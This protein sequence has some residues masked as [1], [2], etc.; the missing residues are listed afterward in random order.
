MA[1]RRENGAGTEPVLKNR[2]WECHAQNGFKPDGSK[3]IIYG[4]G[5]TKTEARNNLKL[6]LYKINAGITKVTEFDHL[7]LSTAILNYLEDYKK[8]RLA[9]TSY[10]RLIQTLKYDVDSTIGSLPVTDVSTYEVQKAINTLVSK[11]RSYSS[12]KKFYVLL[13]EYYKHEIAA[14][15][16]VFN[17]VAAALLPEEYRLDKKTKEKLRIDEENI[18]YYTEDQYKAIITEAFRV[19]QNGKPKYRLGWVFVLLFQTGLRRGEILGL[20]W[21]CVSENYINVKSTIV[22]AGGTRIYKSPKSQSSRRNI[23]LTSLAKEALDQ[24]RP[25]TEDSKYVVCTKNL[26]P[27]RGSELYRTFDS[28]CRRANVPNYGLHATRHT[29]ASFLFNNNCDIKD[30]ST[31][32]GHSDSKTTEMVYIHLSQ[33]RKDRAI[34]NLEKSSSIDL[35]KYFH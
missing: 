3:N 22:E 23:L 30:I 32:L 18:K 31:V 24:L 2:T 26:K 21:D 11:N 35:D 16:L 7:S 1:K 6:K 4:Y 28:I 19:C 33:E 25:I 13:D 29:F 27:L 10:R 12:V 9:E 17:P 15:K 20:K 34:R 14:N 5:K 8:N